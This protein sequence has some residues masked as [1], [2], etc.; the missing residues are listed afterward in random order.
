[1][2]RFIAETISSRDGF[3][4]VRNSATAFMIMP[5]VQ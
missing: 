2:F 5:V 3:G 4:L 1:M